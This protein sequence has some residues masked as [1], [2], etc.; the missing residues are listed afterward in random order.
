MRLSPMTVESI[1]LAVK[2]CKFLHLSI[3]LLFLGL[4]A[5]QA[6]AQE[7][8]IVGTVTDPSGAAVPNVTVTI[9][10]T[11]TGQ[12]RQ[13]VTNG[14]G[15][16]LASN[17][18]IGHY[19]VRVDAS[20]FKRIEQ[21]NIVLQVGDR[22]RLDFKL[23]IG[24]TQEQVT[25]EAAA[26]GVQ[27]DS[28]EVSNVIT[29]KQVA[30]L[31]TN[32]RSIYT[33]VNLTTG[34]SSLQG[35]FQTPTPV[36]GDAN[37]S[38]NGQR[39]GHN[40]YILDGGEDLDRGGAGNFS[41]MPSLESI[42]E[43]RAL[44]SNYSAEYGLSSAATLTTVLKSGT[45]TFHAS[46]WEYVRN[47]AL[48]ARNYFN[49]A[50]AKVAELNFNTYGFNVGGQLPFAKSHPTFFF[51]NM[52]WRK[53]RQG[54]NYNQTVPDP[55]T[56]GGNFGA[57]AITVPTST[58]VA[59]SVLYANCAN[60][61]A[62][63]NG[64]TPGAAFPNNTIPTCMLNRERA[65]AFSGGYFPGTNQRQRNS[66]V[67]PALRRMFVKRSCVLITNSTA[68]TPSSDTG[69]L[70][71]FHRDSAPRCGAVTTSPRSATRSATLRTARWCTTRRSST[72]AC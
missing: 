48:D 52:E 32:G 26:V 19:T 8:T 62:A 6:F 1:V 41:V 15:Q 34:A 55:S 36:G 18:N 50:P 59:D 3:T 49:P 67:A 39:Q 5:T 60:K 44:T 54:G 40:L 45:K 24:S 21:N 58:Q 65:V 56:Y 35:D 16:Y 9:T 71:R 70:N 28:G 27:T 31:A 51:Y 23:E 17:L 53:L 64:L 12:A 30:N 69:S 22:S 33:L 37:V 47:N 10:H 20:G 2:R 72:H 14:D 57:T 11:E 7:A 29:G 61:T 46:G 63:G 4:F 13:A 66:K 42:A 38:F 25:V 43:F 68:K